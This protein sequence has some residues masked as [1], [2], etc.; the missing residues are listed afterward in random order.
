MSIESMAMGT[1]GE[2]G[3]SAAS[4]WLAC[5]VALIVVS[6]VGC[7]V[8]S[9]KLESL[10]QRNDPTGPQ[11]DAGSTPDV[12]LP[13]ELGADCAGAGEC[14]SGFCVDGVCCESACDGVCQECSAQ[15]RCD[16]MPVDD[17]ACSAVAC[18]SSTE[19]ATYPES[20]IADRCAAVG[21]CKT[22]TDCQATETS[23]GALCTN[24]ELTDTE[25]RC[26]DSGVCADARR[27]N[28]ES[29]AL[30]P[31]CRSGLCVDSVCCQEACDGECEVCAGPG[32]SCVGIEAGDA[33]AAC[34]EAGRSCF[35]RGACLL[36]LGSECAAGAECGS[37]ACVTA[38]FGVA[39]QLCCDQQCA[40]GQRCSGDGH[41][42]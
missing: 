24:P 3:R 17:A 21:V 26:D 8:D 10:E 4:A 5:W 13:G 18:P 36:P 20:L 12:P 6:M 39:G 41:C 19:C 15:G 42:V 25:T 23:T 35:G 38:A 28:G 22:S 7:S 30:G 31:E 33:Q 16:V 37:G 11:G 29:C 14:N 1:D 27:A 2:R 40:E 9:R 34:G 32:G